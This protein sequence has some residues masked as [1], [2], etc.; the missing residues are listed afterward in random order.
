MLSRK[1]ITQNIKEDATTKMMR[2]YAWKHKRWPYTIGRLP[3]AKKEVK[4]G[5]VKPRSTTNWPSTRILVY[6]KKINISVKCE[7]ILKA[8]RMIKNLVQNFRFRW[9]HAS[10]NTVFQRTSSHEVSS[11]SRSALMDLLSYFVCG[12]NQNLPQDHIL[13]IRKAS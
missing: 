7:S 11:S 3:R 1:Q 9:S 6:T 2:M 8:T 10:S 13:L 4:T 12:R 5:I